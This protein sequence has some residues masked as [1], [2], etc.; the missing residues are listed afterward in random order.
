MLSS[1][2][3]TVIAGL[4]GTAFQLSKEK[5]CE[6]SAYFTAALN[7]RFKE[8]ETNVIELPDVSAA[9]FRIV[10]TWLNKKHTIQNLWDLKYEPGHHGF[11]LEQEI[12]LEKLA[13][14]K[15]HPLVRAARVRFETCLYHVKRKLNK[16]PSSRRRKNAPMSLAEALE[17]LTFDV[18]DANE[19]DPQISKIWSW[20]LLA[21]LY[22]L[23]DRLMIPRLADA[24]MFFLSRRTH[25]VSCSDYRCSEE[26]FADDPSPEVF[27]APDA[28]QELRDFYLRH[29]YRRFEYG[30]IFDRAGLCELPNEVLVDL[31]L[32]R[33]EF[34]WQDRDV[35]MDPPRDQRLH[36]FA[37]LKA[38]LHLLKPDVCIRH[39]P[40][41][42]ASRVCVRSP[43]ASA[44]LE[45]SASLAEPGW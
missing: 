12:K 14:Q 36:Y 40:E 5:A 30:P 9:H 32:D 42:E 24:V 35:W 1:T 38:Q 3:F 44:P 13:L 18:R 29:L 23:A 43:E 2:E 34:F 28:P 26:L 10:W 22:T 45:A 25:W 16:L 17:P 39:W 31:C 7:G 37:E 21:D 33:N 4:R 19:M 27:Y 6:E 8:G 41:V 20:D 11:S 15:K